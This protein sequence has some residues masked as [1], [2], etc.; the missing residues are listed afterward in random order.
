MIAWKKISSQFGNPSGWLGSLAGFIMAHR[1]S[2]LERNNWAVK[3]LNLKP[4]DHVLEIGFGPG[5]AIQKMAEIITE[6]KIYGMDR[7]NVMLGQAIKRNRE[8]IASGK[9]K[10]IPGDVEELPFFDVTF[11]KV[12]DINS[13]QFWD[14]KIEDLLRIKK[15]IKP[16]GIIMI[17]HQPRKPGSR[18]SETIE[19][20]HTFSDIFRQ[21]GFKDVKTEI[22][23]MKPVSVV[24]ITG[25]NA[26]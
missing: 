25:V 18:D 4:E 2:N 3:M 11:D 14:R 16:G 20:G 13:F 9:V 21:A 17:V 15:Y 26:Q 6:G 10:L 7:S 8:E 12:L 5:V 19:I 1:K 23:R 24:C 22:K